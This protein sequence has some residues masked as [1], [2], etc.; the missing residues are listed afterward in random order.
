[1]SALSFIG[2]SI[3]AAWVRNLVLMLSVAIAY[4]LFGML[5]AFH[6]AYRSTCDDSADQVITTSKTGFSQPLL[7]SHFRQL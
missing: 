1:M 3:T 6:L 4:R 7:I 5:A 2:Q